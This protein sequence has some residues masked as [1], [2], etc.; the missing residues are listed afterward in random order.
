[1]I[2]ASNCVSRALSIKECH[3]SLINC[4]RYFIHRWLFPYVSFRATITSV[5]VGDCQAQRL[6]LWRHRH[7]QTRPPLML[8]RRANN[9]LSDWTG[10]PQPLANVLSMASR[11]WS[12]GWLYHTLYLYYPQRDK[13]RFVTTH[14]VG[15]EGFSQSGSAQ[16]I[17]KTDRKATARRDVSRS[18]S[19]ISKPAKGTFW[20]WDRHL[21]GD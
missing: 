9:K 8:Q 6:L 19:N 16:R 17:R 14:D 15:R 1:M 21:C 4:I 11:D 20:T 3:I 12:A 7:S 13:G 18:V 2:H 5:V 10:E